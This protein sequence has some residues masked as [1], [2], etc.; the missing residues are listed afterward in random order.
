[1]LLDKTTAVSWA[2][3]VFSTAV[4]ENRK[5]MWLKATDACNWKQETLFFSCRMCLRI[6][7][8]IQQLG[9]FGCSSSKLLWQ[10]CSEVWRMQPTPPTVCNRLMGSS[11]PHNGTVTQSSSWEGGEI[12]SGGPKTDCVEYLGCCVLCGTVEPFATGKSIHHTVSPIDRF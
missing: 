5:L 3:Y 11:P 10:L 8:P 2:L 12:W 6:L 9:V 1:M 4:M 7:S